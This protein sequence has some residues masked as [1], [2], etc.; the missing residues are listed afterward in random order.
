MLA[1]DPKSVAANSGL[2]HVLIERKQYPEAEKLIRAALQQQPDDP[3][4]NAQLATV[5]AAQD[6]ADALPLLQKLHAAHPENQA[7]TGMLAQVLAE[8]GDFAAS[9]KLYLALLRQ[10]P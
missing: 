9:D 2:A 3:A 10:V 4:L 8:A 1:E 6:D 7:I 5:L